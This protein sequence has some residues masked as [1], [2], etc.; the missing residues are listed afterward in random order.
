[1][2][3]ISHGFHRARKWPYLYIAID[4]HDT[5]FKGNYKKDNPDKEFYPWAKEVLQNL[6]LNPRVKLIIYT[7]SHEGPARDVITWLAEHKIAIYAL[8]ENPDHKGTELCDFSKK[9]Y[10]DIL[11]EDKAGF[12]GWHDWFLFMKE[13]QRQNEWVSIIDKT[14]GM[15]VTVYKNDGSVASYDK[16]P[17]SAERFKIHHEG[18]CDWN[19][20]ACNLAGDMYYKYGTYTTNPTR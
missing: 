13:L 1:M 17:S 5:I 9:F 3:F 11:L 12:E 7:A 6:S 20:P 15:E 18:K 14:D 10:F 2:N 8:N 16:G 19:C 4:I